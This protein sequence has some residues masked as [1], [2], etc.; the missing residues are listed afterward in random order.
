MRGA[1][2][3]STLRPSTSPEVPDVRFG[4]GVSGAGASLLRPAA[5]DL[6]AARV[7]TTFREQGYVVLGPLLTSEGAVELGRRAETLLTHETPGVFYQPEP[8]SGR[9]EDLAFGAG[10]QGPEQ[11]YRKLE[12]LENDPLFATWIANPAFERL[13][14]AHL[15][16]DVRL[17]RSVLWNKRASGGMAV[18]WHQDDGRFWGLDR[19]PSFQIWTALDPASEQAGCLEVVPGSH[20]AGLASREGGTVLPDSLSREEAASRKVLLPAE[21]GTCILVHNHLWHRTGINQTSNPRRALS[22]SYLSGETRCRRKRR[23]PRTFP[24]VF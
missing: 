19:P 5:A 18:P 4:P 3:P 24:R 1:P 10:W 8:A 14:T 23:A 20:L 15:G 2:G 17:Y 16:E 21:R 12:R 7:L 9:Y 22:V 13:A 6:D 11:R